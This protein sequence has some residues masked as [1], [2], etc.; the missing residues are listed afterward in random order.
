MKQQAGVTKK[1]KSI[2]STQNSEAAG[3]DETRTML[4]EGE[5]KVLPLSH[6]VV[7]YP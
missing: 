7:V 3:C 2:L 4:S 5:F 6:T 1:K